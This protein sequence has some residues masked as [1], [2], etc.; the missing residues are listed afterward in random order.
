MNSITVS[1]SSGQLRCFIKDGTG[2]WRM[3]PYANFSCPSCRD[4]VDESE[5]DDFGVA[6][7][8]YPNPFVNELTV[9]FDVAQPDSDVL[10]EIINNKGQVVRTVA[11][12]THAKGHWKY[13][14]QDLTTESN[15]H[16][17]CRLKVGN[18]FTV[19]KLLKVD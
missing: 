5:N 10:L 18:I 2:N 19:K 13:P 1:T 4:G 7:N 9:E 14:V 3:S 15:Q 17:F 8:V 6:L 16:Y 11:N 12:G